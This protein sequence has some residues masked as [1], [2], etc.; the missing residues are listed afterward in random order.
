M[1]DTSPSQRSPSPPLAGA[2]PQPKQPPPPPR[3]APRP[4]PSRPVPARPGKPL[5]TTA[6]LTGRAASMRLGTTVYGLNKLVM[7][8][9]I[10]AVLEPGVSVRYMAEDVEKI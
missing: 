4:E 7:Q 6:K 3:A 1:I 10:R 5:M 8:G 2:R 9:R